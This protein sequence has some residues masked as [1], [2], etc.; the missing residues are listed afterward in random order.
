MS[1]PNYITHTDDHNRITLNPLEDYV[2]H[3]GEFVNACF[4]DVSNTY[5]EIFNAIATMPYRVIQ[6][7][8]N[9][10]R[11]KVNMSKFIAKGNQ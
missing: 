8:E 11:L 5:I 9:L 1:T 7:Q 4:I 10:L 3:Q 6:S 2:D